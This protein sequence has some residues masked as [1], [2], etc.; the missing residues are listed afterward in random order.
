MRRGRL[1]GVV[2]V[3]GLLGAML[4]APQARGGVARDAKYLGPKLC[5]ACH[6]AT[7]PQAVAGW[8]GS[9]HARALWKIEEADD[10]HKVAADFSK[11]AP[12]PRDQVAY[13]VGSGQRYQS[14]LDRDLKVLPGEWVVKIKS[15]RPREAVDAKQDCLGCHA[16][17][18][19]PETGQWSALGVTCEMCHGPGSEHAGATDK[20]GTIVRPQELDPA[21]RAMICARCHSQ[22]KSKDG[23]YPF[24]VGFLPGD[25][26]DQ[27]FTLLAE[28]PKGAMNS[29]YDE[30][31][32]G[33]GKHLDRGTV[34]TTCHDPH[35]SKGSQ[36][37]QL[38]APVNE[39]CGKCHTNLTG[40]QHSKETLQAVTCATCHMPASKHTF[41]PPKA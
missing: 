15:W 27:S 14:F 24:A 35:G 1:T 40:P 38:L 34:C 3:V 17:G 25:D 4:V 12:F 39:L 11:G 31:R 22:G 18:F 29:Q 2:L 8:T 19:D 13:V 9:A 32:L 5:T 20:K 36:P 21:R 16:S 23:R 10:T 6:Q 7:D 30:L 33:G 26:L 41:V 37:M 28:V